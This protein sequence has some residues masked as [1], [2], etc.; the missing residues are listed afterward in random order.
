MNQSIIPPGT[1][2]LTQITE[3]R[4]GT[5]ASVHIGIQDKGL[6]SF[7]RPVLDAAVDGQYVYVVPIVVEPDSH[8]PYTA[9]AKL[10][11]L[12]GGQPPYEIVRLYD[13]PPLVNDNQYRNNLRELEL[14]DN[15][16]LYVLNVHSLNES[17]ILWRYAPDGTV[18]RLDLARPDSPT[19][20]PAPVAMYVSSTTEMLYLTSALYNPNDRDMTVVRGFSTRGA[21]TLQ[22]TININFM[23]HAAGIT[24]DPQTGTLWVAGFSMYNIPIYPD[25]TRRAYY[26]PYLAEIPSGSDQIRAHTL[27]D[28]DVH[29]LAMPMS[30]I[31]TGSTAKVSGQ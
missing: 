25:P 6:D 3:P 13:D 20:I 29:D 22:R 31:W 17:E 18:E 21:L 19:Y 5:S 8:E 14:D 16:D 10:R 1:L 28:S 27:F 26:E 30:I 24:E 11:L 12:G 23:H 7:G 2:R 4:Y 15:G 9:A